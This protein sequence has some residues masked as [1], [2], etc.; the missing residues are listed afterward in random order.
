MNMNKKIKSSDPKV[1]EFLKYL[2][3]TIEGLHK[4]V[5]H[6]EEGESIKIEVTRDALKTE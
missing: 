1:I 3:C 4:V 5:I 6:V 2:G